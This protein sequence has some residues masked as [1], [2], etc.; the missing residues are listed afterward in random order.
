MKRMNKCGRTLVLGVLLSGLYGCGSIDTK[1]IQN[2]NGGKVEVIGHAGSAF[3]YPMLPFN[4]LPP[5]SIASIEKAL[6]INKADGVEVD[7][8]MSSDS[9]LILFH[10]SNLKAVG[11][12]QQCVSNTKAADLLGRHYDTGP[13]YDLFH[14]ESVISFTD[15]LFYLRNLDKYPALHLDVKNFDDC[16]KGDQQERA[17]QFANLLYKELEES[18]V[19]KDKVIVGS[20]DKTLLKHF[21]TLDPDYSLMLDEN[22][23]FSG[24]MEWALANNMAGLVIGPGIAEK[25]KISL[26]HHHGLF[27]VVFGGRSRSSIIDI[28]NTHPDAIQVNNVGQLNRL[29]D[30]D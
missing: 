17:R 10:D 30:K 7:I 29:L 19:P 8:Q 26:A 18:E 12:P 6:V 13:I 2:L 28:V 14:D 15:L 21:Q 11:E 20:S 5:N 25:E 1:S 23:N 4:P 3:L 16:L 27:V 24:G 22:Q 9:T